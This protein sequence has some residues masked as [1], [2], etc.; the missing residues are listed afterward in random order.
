M[1]DATRSRNW[2]FTLN[3][4]G[5]D[6]V[7]T[8]GAIC[9]RYC[10]MG[11]E[12][13][14]HGT[15][16]L[17]GFM[18]F[19][20]QRTFTQVQKL[21]K[22]LKTH[23]EKAR[24]DIESNVVYCSKDNDIMEF[25]QRP[26]SAPDKGA[27]ERKRWQ[28]AYT[29]AKEGKFKLID[30]RILIPYCRNLQHLYNMHRAEQPLPMLDGLAHEWHWGVTGAGKSYGVRL[31]HPEYFLKPL[32][33]WWDGY[34]FEKV[35]LIEDVDPTHANKFG[36]MLK[37]WCDRY[38]FR[39]E[40]KSSTI[41]IRPEKII[42]TSNYSIKDVFPDAAMHTPLLRR[43]KVHHYAKPFEYLAE[44]PRIASLSEEGITLEPG[45]P[46]RGTASQAVTNVDSY[47]DDLSLIKLLLD[48]C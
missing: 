36:A 11:K 20:S 29:L 12:V 19:K 27:I 46:E 37:V 6:D 4:Y 38:P 17:Q 28:D 26:L 1:S 41:Y 34:D 33:K 9:H 2:C 7:A 24:G 32:N 10:I 14:E 30:E 13:G 42:I 44:R 48:N 31:A 45:A 16:H 21:F 3:N 18:C 39:A 40:V 47:R 25:G 8:I 22:P 43:F 15:P 23:I 5:D 35:V